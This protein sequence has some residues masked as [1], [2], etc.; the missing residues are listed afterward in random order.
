MGVHPYRSF[1][2]CFSEPKGFIAPTAKIIGHVEVGE[3]TS[4]W[5]HAV[6]RGDVMPIKIGRRTNIQ[7]HSLLHGTT[8]KFGVEVGDEV[9]IGHRA[10]IHGAT[11]L[12]RVLIGMG[13]II[14]DGAVVEEGAIVAAGAVVP[15]HMKVPPRKLVAGVPARI[16][17]DV[18][19]E[20]WEGILRSSE[21]YFE[22]SKEYLKHPSFRSF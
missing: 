9:T 18:S 12:S 11:I 20:E 14:L 7:D 16:I 15:P 1:T 2:P 19:E 17:R 4:I 21:R 10:I 6:I 8:G 3:E 22:L 13:A 5:F